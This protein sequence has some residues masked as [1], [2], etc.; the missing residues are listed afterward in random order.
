MP[1]MWRR[2]DPEPITVCALCG[3]QIDDDTDDANAGLCDECMANEMADEKEVADELE[4][5]A[6]RWRLNRRT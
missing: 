6:E 3:E 1:R 5:E 2:T 4:R